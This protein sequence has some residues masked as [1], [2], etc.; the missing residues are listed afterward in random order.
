MRGIVTYVCCCSVSL[1]H[2]AMSWSAVSNI[3]SNKQKKNKRKIAIIFVSIRLNMCFGCPK[4]PSHRDGSSG[5]PQH[6][7]WL[8]IKK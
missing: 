1:P 5:Y 3:G 8:K 6:T 4:E 2:G 7:F